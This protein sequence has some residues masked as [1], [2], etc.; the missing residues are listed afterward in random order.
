MR[1]LPAAGGQRAGHGRPGAG[2]PGTGHGTGR[3]L[4]AAGGSQRH[5]Q[6]GIC[7]RGAAQKAAEAEVAAGEATVKTARINLNYA[8]V[9][10]PI[11]G[12]IGRA[13]VTEGA[14]VGQGEATPLAVVQ[15]INPLFV[16]ITQSSSEFLALRRA[17][18]Q[19][20]L[21][22][23]GSAPAK[24]LLEDGTDYTHPAR[25]LF[26]DL[27][28][29]PSSGQVTLRAE[30]P[31][32]NGLLLPGMYV[33]VLLQQATAT[34]AILLP[35]Q[36]VTRGQ[37]GDTV[38]VVGEGGKVAPR[39]VKVGSAQNGRWVIL[40]GLKP[41]E[42]V[43]VDGFQKMQM[44]P[45]APV[46]PVPWNDGKPAAAAAPASAPA[47]GASGARKSRRRRTSI[48]KGRKT[49]QRTQKSPG[50]ISTGCPFASFAKPLRPL[51]TGVRLRLL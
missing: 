36:A 17:V 5:Q 21:K 51:R 30:V 13:L 28:V 34:N 49:T 15:Q 35:Q 18:E 9:T 32:P 19:G 23:G 27:S 42:Q 44:A 47:S 45:G 39:Q 22:G 16:N 29:D 41:G 6:A 50:T 20:R 2:E 31:N 12:R 3:A 11:S 43:V 8:L 7:Q 10:A 40:D 4:P 38:M 25:L 33:R 46:K 1:A 48:R 37:Q 26:T 24:V 14:L